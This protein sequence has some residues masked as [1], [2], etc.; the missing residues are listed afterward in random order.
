MAEGIG[1]APNVM[2]SCPQVPEQPDVGHRH[3]QNSDAGDHSYGREVAKPK[4]RGQIGE[5][6]SEE[7]GACQERSRIQDIAVIP[8]PQAP[9]E[10]KEDDWRPDPERQETV[11]PPFGV[12]AAD[13][14]G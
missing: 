5:K 7:D 6:V 14:D 3:Q 11:A 4:P 1:M 9:L 10:E 12:P 13:D 2:L 8:G